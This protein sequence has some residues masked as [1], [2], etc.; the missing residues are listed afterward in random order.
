MIRI[1]TP[2][3]S[4]TFSPSIH[5]E[6]AEFE[7]AFYHSGDRPSAATPPRIKRRRSVLEP[8]SYAPTSLTL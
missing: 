1:G 7:V 3:H 4:D 8:A 6:G 2:G 5:G